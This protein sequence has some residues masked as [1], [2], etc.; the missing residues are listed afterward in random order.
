MIH[1]KR[2]RRRPLQSSY[3]VIWQVYQQCTEVI[4]LPPWRYFQLVSC[5]VSFSVVKV[6]WA[7]GARLLSPHLH[8]HL[9]KYMTSMCTAISLEQNAVCLHHWTSGCSWASPAMSGH[10]SRAAHSRCVANIY[11]PLIRKPF[12]IKLSST[13][14]AAADKLCAFKRS[15]E[16]KAQNV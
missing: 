13:C 5:G 8:S 10:R 1:C 9:G 14:S 3:Q 11:L 2:W 6:I 12:C 4:L 15:S 16:L 7:L